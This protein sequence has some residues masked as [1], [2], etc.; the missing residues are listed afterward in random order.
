MKIAFV[1]K[2]WSGKST[3]SALF[4]SYIIQVN[5]WSAL[6]IDAD[7]NMH[8]WTYFWVSSYDDQKMLSKEENTNAI[9]QS[10]INKN[11]KIESVN[12]MVKT[13]PPGR[14]SHIINQTNDKLLQAYNQSVQDNLT[15]LAVGWYSSEQAWTACYHTSLSILENILSHMHLRD[16]DFCIVDMVASTDAFSN[17]LHIQFDTIVLIVEPTRESTTLVKNYLALAQE[18]GVGN[19]III[20]GNKIEWHDDITYVEQEIGQKIE[21]WYAYDSEMKKYMRASDSIDWYVQG[22]IKVLEQLFSQV[23]SRQPLERVTQL[24]KLAELHRKYAKQSYITNELGDLT[25]QIDEVFIQ[26]AQ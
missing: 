23:L 26:W 20:I 8:S 21:A 4:T 25:G 1:G 10:L 17:S 18:T 14:W 22:K 7:T 13:T 3:L 11:Q 6:L 2:W 9:K 5:V 19:K 16:E 15:L 24:Y 12:H